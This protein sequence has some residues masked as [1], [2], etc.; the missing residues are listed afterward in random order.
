MEIETTR[1]DELIAQQRTYTAAQAYAASTVAPSASHLGQ[2]QT[3]PTVNQRHLVHSHRLPYAI[4]LL[5]QLQLLAPPDELLHASRIGVG[6]PF[7]P[8]L[9]LALNCKFHAGALY[10]FSYLL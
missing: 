5:L 9:G 7:Q 3:E 8:K 10:R 6:G 2:L 4:S 1:V